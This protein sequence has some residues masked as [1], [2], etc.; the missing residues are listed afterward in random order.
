MKKFRENSR[1]SLAGP[2]PWFLVCIVGLL[3]EYN[4]KVSARTFLKSIK[5]QCHTTPELGMYGKYSVFQRSSFP[6]SPGS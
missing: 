2:W 4:P 3:L 6:P 1:N 5:L